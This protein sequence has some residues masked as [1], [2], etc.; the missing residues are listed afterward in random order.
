[1]CHSLHAI[2]GAEN[3]IKAVSIQN[4]CFAVCLFV[5]PI[6]N[7]ESLDRFASNFLWGTR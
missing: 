3:E 4:L 7:H 6:I 5:C 1:M 2:A